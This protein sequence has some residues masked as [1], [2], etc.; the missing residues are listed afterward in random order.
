L[1]F[2]RDNQPKE[3]LARA[4]MIEDNA[5]PGSIVGGDKNYDTANFVAGCRE[6]GCTPHVS[7]NNPTPAHRSMR[8]RP[9][10]P[11]T[12]S[13]KKHSGGQFTRD[14]ADLGQFT[15]GFADPGKLSAGFG[16]NVTGMIV[17]R[18][19]RNAALV[20]GD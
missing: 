17:E 12:P 20:V 10:H 3:E 15:R 5:K 19:Q 7:Q 13:P 4:A 1:P 6:R 8:A 2:A 14:F 9:R 16:Q 11:G 18:R